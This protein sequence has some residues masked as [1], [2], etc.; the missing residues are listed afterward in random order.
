MAYTPINW[1]TGDTI[2]AE[3][4]NKMDNGWGVENTQLFSETVTTVDQG[5]MNQGSLTYSQLIDADTIIV[6]FNG[7]NYT[8]PRIDAFGSS[9]YGGFS[10]QGPDFTNFPFALESNPTANANFIYTQN[11]GTYTVSATINGIEVSESFS[12]AVNLVSPS[13]FRIVL[14]TTT[15]QQAY[16]AMS[17]GKLVYAVS[18]GT[19]EAVFKV[20]TYAGIYSGDYVI[21]TGYV[22]GTGD[23]ATENF[24]ATSADGVLS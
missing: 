7:T 24:Y 11:A 23:F 19:N 14:G 2:T 15:W 13:L 16:N 12:E 1:Q 18:L 8:C 4:M 22:S 20:A 6:T 10:E 9:F 21:Q 5:G 3:K 17:S